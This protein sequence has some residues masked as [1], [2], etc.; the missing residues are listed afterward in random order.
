MD[1]FEQSYLEKETNHSENTFYQNAMHYKERKDAF[2]NNY[3]RGILYSVLMSK[4]PLI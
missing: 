1:K 3:K 4:K 2:I